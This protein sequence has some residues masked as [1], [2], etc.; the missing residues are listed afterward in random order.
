MDGLNA[1]SFGV[2]QDDPGVYNY[3]A[4]RIGNRTAQ[5]SC[6]SQCGHR[7]EQKGT[8]DDDDYSQK[9]SFSGP[10]KFSTNQALARYSRLEKAIRFP[11]GEIESDPG[12]TLE[13]AHRLLVCPS[14]PRYVSCP[15][16][17][18]SC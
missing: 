14:D 10:Q 18:I 6:L 2:V 12:R 8:G 7:R 9:N 3:C 1:Y 17:P 15:P 13:W 16:L 4:G 11:S 5:L